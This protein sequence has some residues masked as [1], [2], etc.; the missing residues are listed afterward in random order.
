MVETQYLDMW[1]NK[2]YASSLEEIIADLKTL[3]SEIV[4]VLLASFIW[5][6]NAQTWES[7]LELIKR[8][9]NINSTKN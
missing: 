5:V 4:I 6:H 8:E 7:D 9:L 2:I 1:G 3:P